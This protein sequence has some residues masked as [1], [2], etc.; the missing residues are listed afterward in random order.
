MDELNI[1]LQDYQPEIRGICETKLNEEIGDEAFP[2]KYNVIRKDRNAYGR[3]GGICI[4]IKQGLVF[5]GRT[6]LN[7]IETGKIDHTWCE[8]NSNGETENIVIG[9]VYRPPD[10]ETDDDQKLFDLLRQ[11]EY[12]TT[13]KQLLVMGD[14][15]FREINWKI[16]EAKE[17][18]EHSRF[19]HSINDLYWIQNVLE[20]TRFRINQSPSLLDLVFTRSLGEIGDIRYNQSLGKSDHLV[21]EF[22]FMVEIVE[23]ENEISISKDY[24]KADF[25]GMNNE[26]TKIKWIEEFRDGSVNDCYNIFLN[27]HADIENKFVPVRICTNNRKQKLDWLNKDV[28]K[29]IRERDR[30]WLKWRDQKTDRNWKHYQIMRNKACKVKRLSKMTTEEK[31]IIKIKDDKKQFYNFIKRKTNRKTGIGVVQNEDGSLTKNDIETSDVLNRA[32]QSVFT[33]PPQPIAE[34][35]KD[36]PRDETDKLAYNQITRDEIQC[37]IKKLKEGKAAGPDEI[38]TAFIIRCESA[39]LE[40]LHIIFNKSLQLGEVP[41][42]WRQANVTPIYKKGSKSVALNYRPVSL[43]SVVCKIMERILKDRLTEEINEKCWFTNAQHGFRSKRSTTSNL[44]EFYDEVTTNIDNGNSVDIFFFDLAKAFDM[45]PH[46]RLLKKLRETTTDTYI[47]K[48]ITEYLKERKQRVVIR[49]S[50]SNWLETYSG[51]PQGSVIGPLLFLI[52]VND[53]PQEIN[54]KLNMFADDTKMTSIVNSASQIGI[55]EK[56]LETLESWTTINH[57]KFNVDKC[58]VMHCGPKNEKHKYRLY[59]QEIRKTESEKDL[60]VMVNADMK[61]K[62]QV[63][64]A[65]KKAN[66]T[67]GMIKRNFNYI[68][69][70]A[71]EVLYGVLVR[72]QLEYAIQLWSPYQAGLKENIERTQRRAT[73]L[74]KGIRN[75]SYEERLK[76]LNLM[77]TQERRDRGDSIMTY[78]ILSN[79][80]DMGTFK[81]EDSNEHRTRG[82]TRKLAVIRS[83]TEIRRNFFTNRIVNRWNALGQRTVLSINSEAFKKAYDQEIPLKFGGST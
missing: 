34:D 65:I 57:M 44:L 21:L 71:F 79:N 32:F 54:S 80:I 76:Y 25:K 3:G 49:G 2:S 43:T 31:V 16:G 62:D 5:R 6:D 20:M 67:L 23:R 72:P 82:H 51:V 10:C 42:I 68:N 13:N 24:C 8:I 14:F 70:E 33:K 40:P 11:V 58:S 18:S 26:L 63:S 28:K 29:A 1:R 38:S 17:N 35:T 77:T 61:F 7:K 66:R 45:V 73:K 30:Q 56:D 64:A 74:V 52:Y 19:L 4:M 9:I 15:N 53:L 59:G 22:T 39:I 69:R 47:I 55:I 41:D 50:K 36:I 27:K 75:R 12:K 83:R 37:A 78:N 46:D 48:W 60:G 81:L